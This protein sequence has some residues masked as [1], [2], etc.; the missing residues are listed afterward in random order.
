[1]KNGDFACSLIKKHRYWPVFCQDEAINQ[2]FVGKNV[3]NTDAVEGELDVIPYNIWCFKEPDY[4]CKMFG[5][6]AGLNPGSDRDHSRVWTE[7]GVSKSATIKYAEPYTVH[8]IY[9]HDV[10]NDN[11]LFHQVPSIEETWTANSWVCHVFLLLLAVMEVN[12]YP[13]MRHFVWNAASQ[14]T[15]I[16]FC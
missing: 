7:D 11:N 12:A 10:D 3:G 1:M 9:Q 6:A 16:A 5:T 14:I 4:I 13:T 8:F 15:L 2:Y